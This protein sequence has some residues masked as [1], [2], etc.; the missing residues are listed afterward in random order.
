LSCFSVS[1]RVGPRTA[2]AGFTGT[3]WPVI[4][5]SNSIRTA[6]SCC[7]TSGGAS[8]YTWRRHA[9]G[10]SSTSGRA[11]RTRQRTECTRVRKRGGCSRNV[12]PLWGWGA[13]DCVPQTPTSNSLISALLAPECAWAGANSSV[14]GLLAS[15]GNLVSMAIQYDS[16]SEVVTKIQASLPKGLAPELRHQLSAMK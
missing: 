3:I 11:P 16:A 4:S 9:A 1:I 8:L 12:G 7:F 15:Y 13:E 5:Q 2:A 10:S 6:A 14:E